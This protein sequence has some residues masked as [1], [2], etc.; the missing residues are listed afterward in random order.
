MVVRRYTKSEPVL[1]GAYN[2]ITETAVIGT[3]RKMHE[4]AND[5]LCNYVTRHPFA[6]RKKSKFLELLICNSFNLQFVSFEPSASIGEEI[7]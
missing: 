3:N 6:I 1:I 2:N 7:N 5:G 4:Y